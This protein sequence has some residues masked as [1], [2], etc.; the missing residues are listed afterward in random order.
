MARRKA[1]T[2][3]TTEKAE[4]AR[5][6]L[7]PLSSIRAANKNPKTHA[8]DRLRLS[9]RRFGFVAPLVLDESTG[10]LVAGHGRAEA[11][12]A[13]RAAAEE[14]PERVQATDDDWLVPVLRGVSFATE[15][16]AEAYLLADNRI[17]E[18]GGWDTVS[19][20]EMIRASQDDPSLV[21]AAG[22]NE[23]EVKA[24]LVLNGA[25]DGSLARQFGV[26]PFSTLDARGG[27]WQR[28][29]KSWR[30]LGL[31]GAHG[32]AD[33]LVM[34]YPKGWASHGA[35]G[36]RTPST[37]LFDPVLVELA[38][39]WFA[40]P[41]GSVL[42]PFAG[43]VTRGAVAA[44]LGHP[45]VGVDLR[46]QQVASN[47]EIW[48]TVAEKIPGLVGERSGRVPEPTWVEGDSRLLSSLLPAED[49]FDLLLSCPPYADLEVYS[50]DP[51][52]LSTMDYSDF[53]EAYR[54]IIARSVE[55]L[56]EDRFA[57]W[58]VSEIRGP[59]GFYRGFVRDTVDAFEASGARL[60]NEAVLLNAV[61]N[62]SLVAGRQ[63]R[64]G[65]KLRRNHQ[66]VLV[67]VKGDWRRAC[68]ACGEVRIEA[69]EKD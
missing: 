50:D 48:A 7:L 19:L 45:Y 55:R 9:I 51:R 43:G 54:M 8:I 47:R 20:L 49:R 57:V 16:D 12:R 53:R 64:G 22:W 24:L 39:S 25:P 66:E 1:G 31:D 4:A 27:D 26:P 30:R 34:N 42:D 37:S 17:Q 63:F 41:G 13:M 56:R 38:C 11:L 68:D 6:E 35:G 60:Y 5:I 15:R 61:G 65:R 29:Q 2:K 23:R 32:R 10:R 40:P 18:L 36:I 52:D 69:I 62:G 28:R 46:A 33:E 3:A 58:V 44:A 21:A 67:F 59:D 14:P